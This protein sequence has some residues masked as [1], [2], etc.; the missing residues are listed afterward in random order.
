MKPLR[1]LS[2]CLALTCGT[3]AA[4]V[5]GHASGLSRNG[6]MPTISASFCTPQKGSLAIGMTSVGWLSFF[7]TKT[8]WVFSLE[9][10]ISG[11]AVNL[12]IASGLNLFFVPLARF[13][14]VATLLHTWN[15]PWFELENGQTYLGIRGI[16]WV[17]LVNASLGVLRHIGGGDRDH[18]W[19]VTA[20]V[21]VG[22]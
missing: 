7:G 1:A 2:L 6:I 4:G 5:P 12:G 14:A 19:V 8:G 18:D 9:P 16:M 13:D 20:G 15:D 17:P 21:G 10:G 11:G 22:I 3:A